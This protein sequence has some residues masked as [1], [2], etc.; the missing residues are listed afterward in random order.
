MNE[1]DLID[2]RQ[3]A[4][5]RIEA[6]TG[7]DRSVMLEQGAVELAYRAAREQVQRLREIEDVLVDVARRGAPHLS[8]HAVYELHGK[9]QRDM[10]MGLTFAEHDVNPEGEAVFWRQR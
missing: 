9:V 6:A 10:L 2:I 7:R 4:L 8:S 5:E 1:P 3:R